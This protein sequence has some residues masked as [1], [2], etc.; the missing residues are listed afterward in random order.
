MLIK[1]DTL[2]LPCLVTDLYAL[3][4]YGKNKCITEIMVKTSALKNN[5]KF[6]KI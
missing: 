1:F 4:N 5:Y 2:N 6:I 3:K